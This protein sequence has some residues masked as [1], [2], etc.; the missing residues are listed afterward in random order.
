[1]RLIPYSDLGNRRFKVWKHVFD[2]EERWW[3]VLGD[4]TAWAADWNR[5]RGW[6]CDRS[7]EGGE[8]ARREPRSAALLDREHERWLEA[9]NRAVEEARRERRIFDAGGDVRCYIGDDGVTVYA[10]SRSGRLGTCFRPTLAEAR[11]RGVSP[12]ITA[13][14]RA[15]RKAAT[16]RAAVRRTA[17]RT[18]SVTEEP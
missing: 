2:Q 9:A 17:R 11:A 3:E 4:L 1:M 13:S 15:A 8:R 6:G 14:E 7:P 18:S 16:L 5:L 10:D 12:A